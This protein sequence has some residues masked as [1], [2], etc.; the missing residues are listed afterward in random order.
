MKGLVL[1]IGTIV[2]AVSL[3]YGLGFASAASSTASSATKV[4]TASS[5][6]GKILVDSHGRTL[7]LFV[8]DK[9]GKSACSGACAAYW[10]PLIASGK[11][12][13]IAGVEGIAARYDPSSRRP[14]A[15]HLPAPPALPVRRRH[16]QGPAQR[17]GPQRLRRVLVGAL[18]H[19]QQ[20]RLR[21][22]GL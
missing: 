16:G 17:S 5:S 6:L 21:P 3:S 14:P 22:E 12:H 18:A 9:K 7:Y 20:D 19:R 1:A 11:P 2:V 15:G 13:A 4:G 10:P 8:K